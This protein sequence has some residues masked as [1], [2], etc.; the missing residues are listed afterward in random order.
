MLLDACRNDPTQ[1]VI[2]D[3]DKA[4]TPGLGR[5]GTADGSLYAFATAPG[6]TAS[7]GTGDHSPFSSAMLAHFGKA[8]L[9]LRSILTLVRMEVYERSRGQQLPYVEDA[10]PGT[11][12]F[13]TKG[14]PLTER[15]R[16]LMAMAGIDSDTRAQIESV[17]AEYDV[18]LAPLYGALVAAQLSLGQIDFATRQK[19][20]K[21]AAEEFIKLRNDLATLA[22]SDPAVAQLRAQ[23]ERDLSNGNFETARGAL[24][25]AIDL[26]RNSGEQL[27]ARLRE[28]NLS[29]AASRSIR[30]GIARSHLE[31]RDAAADF[32]AAADLTERWDRA[33]AWSYRKI[34]A[35]VLQ[36]QGEQFGERA[37]L[38]E[39][40]EVNR[41][42]LTLTPRAERQDDWALTQH[43]HGNILE[44]LA[45]RE[46]SA[47]RFEQALDAYNLALEVRTREHAPL[48]W[49]STQNNIGIALWMLGLIENDTVRLERAL[50]AFQL[51]L[52]DIPANAPRSNGRRRRAISASCS[53]RSAS[54]S[55][56]PAG[57]SRRSP[58]IAGVA[59]AYPRARTAGMGADPE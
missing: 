55:A 9:E 42:A 10:L 58:P 17:A 36:L 18:P 57:S 45:G 7:D 30:A 4:V 53:V 33:V 34:Q 23:A 44:V 27:E 56:E 39:A 50:V 12:F 20:L 22:S 47:R 41:R 35:D 32:S 2:A 15:D 38:R 8:G 54:A 43:Q 14:E 3:P 16:L 29:E 40:I 48:L 51:T 1:A 6:V 31:Y 28:R 37:A 11:V 26:D 19:V 24:T 52:L 46:Q 49:A 21:Q 59:G 5:I 13:D 25:Q